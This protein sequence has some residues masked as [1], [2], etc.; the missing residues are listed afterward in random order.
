ML[1][2][3]ALTACQDEFTESCPEIPAGGCRSSSVAC[4]D[5]SCAALYLCE[6][7]VWQLAKVC[8]NDGSVP[9]RDGGGPRDT[10]TNQFSFD[11]SIDAPPGANGGL[12]CG[13]LQTPDCS[14]GFALACASTE[15]CGCDDLFVCNNGGWD[16]W[17]SCQNG[18]P[19]PR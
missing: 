3:V 17:G 18:Q 12:G 1:G 7:G 6:I 15:C 14:L 16:A 4:G 11:A 10:G 5:T 19:V 8:A 13:P 9:M 2:T